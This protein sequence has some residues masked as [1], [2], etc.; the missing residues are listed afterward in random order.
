MP[1]GE[2]EGVLAR[3]KATVREGF[4]VSTCNRTEVYGLV[5]HG[6]P[7]TELLV[8]YLADHGRADVGDVRS[9]CYAHLDADAVRHALRV[10]SGLDSMV[11]GED[12]IQFQFK[13]AIAAARAA[14]ALGATLD[15]LGTAALACGKRVRTS[16]GV[17]RHSVSLESLA[18]RA[19]AARLEGLAKRRLLIVGAGE[20][21][22]LIV[23]Q[24]HSIGAHDITIVSRRFVR[25][26]ALAQSANAQTR[27]WTELSQA[28]VD[29]DIVFA[30]TAAPRAVISASAFTERIARRAMDPLLCVDLGM[31]RAVDSAIAAIPGVFLISLDELASMAH[32]HRAAR[33]AHIPAAEAIVNSEVARYL[34]WLETRDVAHAIANLS[35]QA[36]AVAAMELE[37]VMPRLPSLTPQERAAVTELAHRIVRKLVHQPIIALKS[38]PVA[39]NIAVLEES[40]S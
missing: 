27:H 40:V 4:I 36:D 31:P 14:G 8:R 2:L 25:A 23:R 32:A 30:C 6:G 35:A 1:P 24:L 28:L 22:T 16:T 15:R 33:R 13:H 10:A 29:A 3:L 38:Q 20:S 17:G 26:T 18:V 7:G 19:A 39:E 34:E 37:R 12:Q 5:D 9:S 11:L 21:A